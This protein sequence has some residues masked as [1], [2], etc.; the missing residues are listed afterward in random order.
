[1]VL[2]PS[3]ATTARLMGWNGMGFLLVDE[4]F[5]CDIVMVAGWAPENV[6]EGASAYTSAGQRSLE[7]FAEV[8]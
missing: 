6:I 4:R 1:M 3:D 8:I 7:R 5:V 2:N